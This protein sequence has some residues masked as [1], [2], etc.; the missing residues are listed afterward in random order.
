MNFKKS[1]QKNVAGYISASK[2][3]T[4]NIPLWSNH[5]KIGIKYEPENFANKPA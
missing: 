3:L 1:R 4:F 5:K 2:N